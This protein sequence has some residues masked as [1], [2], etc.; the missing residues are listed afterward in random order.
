MPAVPSL[1]L[2]SGEVT[3]LSLTSAFAAFANEGTV[4]PP[5]LIRRAFTRDGEMLYEAAPVAQSAVTPATAYLIT[6]ML[7][8]V[9]SGG[10]ASR[11]RRMG[12]RLP[13]A[14]K[15][16]TTNEYRDAW[17]VGYTPKLA[18]GVWV[19]YDEPRTIISRGYAAELAVPMWAR[20]M[21]TATRD[22]APESFRVPAS[23]T[24]VDICRLSGKLATD[25]C[26]R[27]E[28]MVYT[29]YF[30]RGTEPVE[31]CLHPRFGG[32][33]LY[34]TATTP[35]MPVSSPPRLSVSALA[36]ATTAVAAVR[37]ASAVPAEQAPPNKKRGFW[38][39]LLGVGRDQKR[40]PEKK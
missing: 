29:E 10:T 7:E 34:A 4:I 21:I 37:Q 20:F 8:D 28:A 17:F 16:G 40:V 1:A 18:T 6:S 11:A 3:L 31:S 13:A 26:R 9:V 24:A 38:A 15:T 23:V 25:S 35:T 14:G 32:G 30:K 39:R 2:G 33:A 36:D 22:H 12:F 5:T 27:H 19:G